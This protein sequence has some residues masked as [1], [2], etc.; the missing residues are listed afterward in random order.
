VDTKLFKSYQLDRKDFELL[1]L[2]SDKIKSGSYQLLLEMSVDT[3][4]QIGK[5]GLLQFP[6]GDYLYTGVHRTALINRVMRHLGHS[7]K[8]RWHIDYLTTHP[9][10]LIHKVILYPG[11]F[12]ECHLNRE[13]AQFSGAV[14]LHPGFGNSDCVN[15]CP[16]HLLF[17][18]NHKNQVDHWLKKIVSLLLIEN[19]RI[20]A[21]VME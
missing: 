11:D 1:P 2:L 21:M 9:A 16:A 4:I 15:K 6:R 5:L 19:D 20:A 17:L 13:F 8:T 3:E 12:G 14:F 7:K 18:G 10:L